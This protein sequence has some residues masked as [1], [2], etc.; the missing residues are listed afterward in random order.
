MQVSAR[1][2]KQYKNINKNCLTD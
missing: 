2:K 1:N